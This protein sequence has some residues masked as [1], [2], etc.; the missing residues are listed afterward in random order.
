MWKKSSPGKFPKVPN[1]PRGDKNQAPID[2]Y[3][4]SQSHHTRKSDASVQIFVSALS[5]PIPARFSFSRDL[6]LFRTFTR[7]FGAGAVPATCTT[8]ER[9]TTTCCTE[10]SITPVGAASP[11]VVRLSYANIEPQRTKAAERWREAFIH[12]KLGG[13]EGPASASPHHQEQDP[14]RSP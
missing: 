4:C 14:A 2:P 5:L 9:L 1:K 10:A 11:L 3:P 8:S 6:L 7:R 13:G 12:H